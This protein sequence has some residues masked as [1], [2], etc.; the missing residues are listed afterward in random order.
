MPMY[1]GCRRPS[2]LREI[3]ARHGVTRPRVLGGAARGEDQEGS[4]LDLLIDPAPTTTRFTLAALQRSRSRMRT[5]GGTP[6]CERGGGGGG[7]KIRILT[8]KVRKY[9]FPIRRMS[10]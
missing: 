6:G 1:E 5:R 8:I 4:D 2:A 9:I 3:V 7:H 10:P